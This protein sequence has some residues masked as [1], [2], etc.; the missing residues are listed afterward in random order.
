MLVV[1]EIYSA[2]EPKLPDIEASRLVEAIGAHGH[3]DVR[4]IADFEGIVDTLVGQ[5]R[6]GDLVLTLGAG[7]ISTL[8]PLLLERVQG[9]SP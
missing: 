1:T 4:F 6:E 8:G 2:G 3:R 9:V 7:N 5:L